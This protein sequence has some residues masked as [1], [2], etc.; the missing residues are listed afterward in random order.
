MEH[1]K[2]KILA[3]DSP[4][5]EAH[6]FI[7]RCLRGGSEA[8]ADRDEVSDDQFTARVEEIE[9]AIEGRNPLL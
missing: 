6:R 1:S 2:G 9:C 7:G 8:L 3:I 4:F 5:D